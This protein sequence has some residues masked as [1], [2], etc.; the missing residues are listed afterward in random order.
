MRSK[1]RSF[2]CKKNQIDR[3]YPDI[4]SFWLPN[5]KPTNTNDMTII[6]ISGSQRTRVAVKNSAKAETSLIKSISKHDQIGR[7]MSRAFALG[8]SYDC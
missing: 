4:F 1:K 8:G 2:G 7:V 6:L 5:Q 3:S